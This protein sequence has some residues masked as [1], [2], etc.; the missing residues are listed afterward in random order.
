MAAAG[1]LLWIGTQL[2][3]LVRYDVSNSDVGEVRGRKGHGRLP[4]SVW[5]LFADPFS[6]SVLIV[7]HNGDTYFASSSGDVRPRWLSKL[8]GIRCVAATWIKLP[9]SSDGKVR[10]SVSGSKSDGQGGDKSVPLALLGTAFGS[11]FALS[12][13]MRHERNDQVR[14][15]WS[16]PTGERIVGIRVERVA[17]S[18]VGTV[19]TEL[20]LYMLYGA[21]TLEELFSSEEGDA[22]YR[23]G[24]GAKDS[25]PGSSRLSFESPL[26][27]ELQFMSGMASGGFVSRRFVWAARGGIMHAQLALRSRRATGSDSVTAINANI[28]EKFVIGWDLLKQKSGSAVPMACNL[29]MYHILVLY[30]GSIYAFNHLSGELTQE[31][32]IWSPDRP[33]LAGSGYGSYLESPAVGFARDTM[34]DSMWVYTM[35]GQV[36]R[37][38]ATDE[39]QKE[40]WR[41]AKSVG[42][43]DLAMALAPLVSGDHSDATNLAESREAVFEAQ[44]D[45]AAA[46]GDW[47]TAVRLYAK[48]N[49]AIET[50]LIDILS[51]CARERSDRSY[52][53]AN[54]RLASK[55]T[56]KQGVDESPKPELPESKQRHSEPA[57]SDSFDR[58]SATG[59]KSS[60]DQDE[61]RSQN[62]AVVTSEASQE[63]SV[64]V[65]HVSSFVDT[66]SSRLI[67]TY[68]VC[69]LDTVPESRP[70]QRTIVGTMLVHFYASCLS[71]MRGT[72]RHSVQELESMRDDF[73]LFLADHVRDLHVPTA[74]SILS[75]HRCYEQARDVALLAEDFSRAADVS[76]LHCGPSAALDLLLVPQLKRKG[77]EV[78]S[79]LR[80]ITPQL[81]A[82]APL[83]LANAYRAVARSENVPVDHFYLLAKLC[84]IARCR[85]R[86]ESEAAYDVAVDYA[87]STLLSEDKPFFETQQFLAKVDD[88]S[89]EELLTNRWHEAVRLLFALHADIR[90]AENALASYSAFTPF[91]EQYKTEAMRDTL[92]DI[93][94]SGLRGQFWKLIVQVY[95]ALGMHEEAVRYALAYGGAEGS[96]MAE[97][98][99][100]Y[101]ADEIADDERT[102]R[103]WL[104]IAGSAEDPLGVAERSNGFLRVDDVLPLM[105]DFTRAEAKVTS[106][107]A[108]SLAEHQN[109]AAAAADDAQYTLQQTAAMRDD[110]AAAIAWHSQARGAPCGHSV[111]TGK[112]KECPWCGPA[113][114]ESISKPLI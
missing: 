20:A 46:S 19:A 69:K 4:A 44:A 101:F 62:G 88:N 102:H 14:K 64:D 97:S 82:E 12:L 100:K 18:F 81:A 95:G 76:M 75:S 107:I 47:D 16:T 36:A 33:S 93:L 48:T 30:P 84:D 59:L 66:S 9:F 24:D 86:D 53:A 2:G 42:R 106:A 56:P 40:A 108:T 74:M 94:R 8:R 89:E 26:P 112:S 79:I 21:E 22:V 110:M 103:L 70:T 105:S 32:Q 78:L 25:R 109:A 71:R 45:Q 58:L 31:I 34:V 49:R 5:R 68:L 98:H 65:S 41:A 37:I 77:T 29:S 96:R 111:D 17:G 54:E 60:S 28:T 1:D 11:V 43:F 104:E 67:I 23:I 35:D 90:S 10:W 13:D 55:P 87:H 50:V 7:L 114:V 27:S 73:R 80:K 63:N 3:R 83:E 51:A 72:S 57:D 61:T 38:V 85:N 113:A 6:K 99:T 91:A 52:G 39:E 92:S 15:V